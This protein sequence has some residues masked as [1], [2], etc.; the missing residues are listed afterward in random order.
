[1]IRGAIA[2]GLVL[3]IDGDIVKHRE[4]IVTTTILI[5]FITTLLYG[6]IMPLLSKL[7]VPFNKEKKNE[8]EKERESPMGSNNPQESARDNER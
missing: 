7:L 6:T 1:M 5:I 8:Y 3:T 4:V 2:F